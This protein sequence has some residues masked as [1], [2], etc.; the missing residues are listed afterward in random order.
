LSNTQL[1]LGW[2]HCLELSQKWGK[3]SVIADSRSARRH[4]IGR[5][6]GLYL[7]L[8]QMPEKYCHDA[9]HPCINRSGD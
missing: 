5:A 3:R 4:M 6:P 9:R 2:Q 8:L 1:G 7:I